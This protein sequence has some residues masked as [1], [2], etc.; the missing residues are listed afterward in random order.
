MADY[1]YRYY[2]HPE[3]YDTY[4]TSGS[5]LRAL[6][7]YHMPSYSHLAMRRAAS[8]LPDYDVYDRV[9]YLSSA[10]LE[11]NDA[12]IRRSR[13]RDAA[14]LRD[15]HNA[16]HVDKLH[17][18]MTTSQSASKTWEADQ[19]FRLKLSTP[20]DTSPVAESDERSEPE[21][22]PRRPKV[23]CPEY[24]VCG[25]DPSDPPVSDLRRRIRRT[26]NKSRRH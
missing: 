22:E 1:T 26:L 4:F 10:T 5:P 12:A 16:I 25:G 11:D 21:E 15:A 19:G 18:E 7:S 24:Y 13:G 17:E 8:V 3:L 20:V 6:R 2:A 14:L 23:V 9:G